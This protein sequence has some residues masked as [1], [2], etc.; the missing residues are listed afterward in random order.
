[1]NNPDASLKDLIYI[2]K[3]VI[4]PD[5]CDNIVSIIEEKDWSPHSWYSSFEDTFYTEKSKGLDSK[6]APADT[7]E[8]LIPFIINVID[9]YIE[10]NRYKSEKT[11]AIISKFSQVRLNRYSPG[12]I[13][14]QHH[15]HIHSLFDGNEKGIPVLSIVL[16][17]ND[18]YEG[19]DLFFWDN[20]KIPLGKGDIVIFPSLFLFPHGVTE[21]TKGKRFSAVSWGW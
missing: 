12:Q 6:L 10:K 19:G 2:K 17:L 18:D 3:R 21:V 16:N 11:W 15:D 8:L 1:M 5:V 4:P 20:Y 13:M 14:H 7:H 9:L